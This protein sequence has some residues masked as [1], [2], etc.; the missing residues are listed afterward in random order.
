[1]KTQCFL[2]LPIGKFSGGVPPPLPGPECRP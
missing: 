1:M 2:D